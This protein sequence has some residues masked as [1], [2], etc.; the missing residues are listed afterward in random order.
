MAFLLVLILVRGHPEDLVEGSKLLKLWRQTY[1]GWRSGC[2]QALRL[3]CLR[4]ARPLQPIAIGPRRNAVLKRM[5]SDVTVEDVERLMEENEEAR[6]YQEEI[7]S[8][9]AGSSHG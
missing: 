2:A 7:A 9:I 3:E 5:Q 6:A 8:A 4:T 1:L